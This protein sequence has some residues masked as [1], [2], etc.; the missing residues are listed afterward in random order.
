M[1]QNE[2][3]EYIISEARQHGVS[4]MEVIRVWHVAYNE[5]RNTHGSYRN[6]KEGYYKKMNERYSHCADVCLDYIIA[7]STVRT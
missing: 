3:L 4:G 1:D 6:L 7:H 2:M 5:H